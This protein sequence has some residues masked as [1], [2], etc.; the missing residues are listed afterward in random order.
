MRHPAALIEPGVCYGRLDIPVHPD[1]DIEGLAHDPLLA[2]STVVWTSPARRCGALA[3]KIAD[4]LSIPLIADP[5]LL[6]LDFGDVGRK[7][8]G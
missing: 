4:A 1:S 2:G 7:T 3:D 5:R 8:L 6:E